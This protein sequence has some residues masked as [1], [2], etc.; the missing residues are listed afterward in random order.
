[1]NEMAADSTPWLLLFEPIAGRDGDYKIYNQD[2]AFVLAGYI[3]NSDAGEPTQ[4]AV[5]PTSRV[6]EV[7]TWALIPVGA[8]K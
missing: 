4:L 8:D 3:E 7:D 1:M 5:L 6:A 2:K